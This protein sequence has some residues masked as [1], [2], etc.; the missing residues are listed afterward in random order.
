MSS[1]GLDIPTL[2]TIV[3]TTSRKCRAIVGRILR[4]QSGYNV[5]PLL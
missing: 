4:K 2:N 1:E 5:K 3:L